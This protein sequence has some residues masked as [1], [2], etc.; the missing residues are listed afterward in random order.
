MPAVKNVGEPCAGEPHA[1]FEVAAG[2]NQA[3]RASTC[4]AA[5]APLADPTPGFDV[6]PVKRRCRGHPRRRCRPD[7]L[8][9]LSAQ[10]LTGWAGAP[11]RLPRLEG[12]QPM[13]GRERGVAPGDSSRAVR[14]AAGWVERRARTGGCGLAPAPTD[15]SGDEDCSY[16]SIAMSVRSSVIEVWLSSAVPSGLRRWTR[17]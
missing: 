11:P 17:R 12:D 16:E 3:S 9:L 10:K 15:G 8:V 2:G 5:Q 6:A 13:V 1:R 14:Y 4:R 7:D